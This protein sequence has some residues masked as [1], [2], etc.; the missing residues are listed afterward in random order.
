M[1][2]SRNREAARFREEHLANEVPSRRRKGG[3]YDDAEPKIGS[4]VSVSMTDAYF[5]RRR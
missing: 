3:E 1:T 2:A 4:F 5:S